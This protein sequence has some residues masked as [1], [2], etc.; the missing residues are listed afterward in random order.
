MAASVA[1]ELARDGATRVLVW[2]RLGERRTD[3]NSNGLFF[4]LALFPRRVLVS[5]LR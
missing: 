1:V 4:G 5:A 2:E 3:G